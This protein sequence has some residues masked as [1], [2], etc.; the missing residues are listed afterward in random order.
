MKKMVKLDQLKARLAEIADLQGAGA[1]LHWDQQ[2]YMPTG[3]AAARAEQLATLHK[4]AH[5]SFTADE[6]GTLLDAAA[7][8]TSGLDYDSDE[9]SL[10]RVTR[11]DYDKARKIPST[12]VAELTRATSLGNEAW[13]QA[14]THSDFAHFQP[15]LERI[16]ALEI[17]LAEA[18]GYS[19]KIYDALLDQY[20]PG[21]KTAQVAATFAEIKP[22]L[23]RLAREIGER[24]DLV[25]D[26]VLHRTYD[27]QTQWD[28]GVEVIKRFGYDFT[29]GRQDRAPHPFTIGFSLND[30]RITTRFDKNFLPTAL[31]GTLHEC[32]HA[33]YGLGVSPSL[34]RTPLAEGASL[35]IHE[36]QSRLWENLVGRSRGFWKFYYPRLKA[37][38]PKQL[39]DVKPEDFYKAINK[40]EPSLIRVEADEATYNLHIMLRFDL[41]N[42]ML[43]QKVKI[44]DLPDAWNAKM[45]EYLGLTPPD[46]AQ[47]VLQ[48][49]HWSDGYLGYFPTYALGNLISAQ[50]WGQALK[51]IHDLPSQIEA[52]EFK[53]LREWLRVK[54]HQHGRKFMPVELLQR[55]TETGL[56]AEPYLTYIRSKFSDIYQL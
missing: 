11:R 3:G 55:I 14:R 25:D 17:Q 26:S 6:I 7:R 1:V 5:E 15:H 4:L 29:R 12:L 56:Q 32:G 30:V 51:E 24:K 20:E 13:V 43:E 31:F 9:A 16:V 41:E 38:F 54:I 40:V 18:L 21:M 46:D 10:V 35:G 45:E 49:I 44:A 37:T 42:A 34:E 19:E 2:T 48:D 22:Y 27:E 23:I 33:L 28:F 50:L 52:G 47:G 36:S 53:A 39:A 8:E